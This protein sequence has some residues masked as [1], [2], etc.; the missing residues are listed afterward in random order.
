MLEKQ[1]YTALFK[2]SFNNLPIQVKFW[3]GTTQDFGEG[4]PVIFVTF[5]KV[6][7]VHEILKMLH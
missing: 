4:A 5:K 3:N 1:F 2:S 7:P 6:I